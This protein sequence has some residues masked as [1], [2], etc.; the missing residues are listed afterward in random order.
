MEKKIGLCV[1]NF[2]QGGKDCILLVEMNILGKHKILG[3]KYN[4]FWTLNKNFSAGLSKLHFTC[5]G[6]GGGGYFE[7]LIFFESYAFDAAGIGKARRK[8]YVY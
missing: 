8:K 2:L 5:P 6:G 7:R 1:K 4:F 3:K